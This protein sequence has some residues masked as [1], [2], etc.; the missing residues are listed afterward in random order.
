MLL[1]P[2]V[3]DVSDD[4]NEQYKGCL[5]LFDVRGLVRRPLP[6]VCGIYFR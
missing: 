3:T 6:S 5:T 4:A 2:R 1:N